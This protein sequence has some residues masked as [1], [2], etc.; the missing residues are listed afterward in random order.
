MVGAPACTTVNP[1]PAASGSGPSSKLPLLTSSVP[2]AGAGPG[3][4]AGG[5]GAGGA[6]AGRVAPPAAHLAGPLGPALAAAAALVVG[7]ERGFPRAKNRTMPTT[8]RNAAAPPPS[9]TS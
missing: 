8:A 4:G 3:V 6:G 5:A 1:G 9:S 2:A 7:S